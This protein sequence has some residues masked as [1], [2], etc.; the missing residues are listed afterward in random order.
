M[1]ACQAADRK[2]RAELKKQEALFNK[3]VAVP[4][5]ERTPAILIR[6]E[7][8]PGHKTGR[9]V[10]GPLVACATALKDTSTYSKEAH[11]CRQI[12]SRIVAAKKKIQ[13]TSRCMDD[14]RKKT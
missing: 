7:I 4:V 2:A 9:N 11:Q 1:D 13:D 14:A 5:P 3:G 12:Q 10:A 6:N 8:I